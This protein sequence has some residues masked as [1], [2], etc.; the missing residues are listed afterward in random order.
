MSTR[1]FFSDHTPGEDSPG[2]TITIT[3]DELHHLRHVNRAKCG[4]VIEVINGKGSLYS[5]K[6]RTFKPGEAI[7]DIIH[8]ETVPQPPTDIIIAV[9]LLKQRAMGILLEKLCEIGVAEIIPLIFTHTD[10]KFNPGRLK[11][12]QKIPPQALKVNKHLW[13]TKIHEPLSLDSF[14]QYSSQYETKIMLDINGNKTTQKDWQLPL[15]AIIGPPGDFCEDERE[16]L[17][18]NGFIRYNI[19]DAVLKSETAALSIAAI[20]KNGIHCN[21]H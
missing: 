2:S 15:L 5:G 17:V 19:N 14:I 13:C 21:F 1:R 4:D 16:A 8:E 7:I 20:L 3:G 10:E 12:W 18:K 9:S 11:K 6:I